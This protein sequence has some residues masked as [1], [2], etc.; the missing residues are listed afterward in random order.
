M[1]QPSLLCGHA[2]HADT[3]AA[4]NILAAGL[5]VSAFMKQ[6]PTEATAQELAHA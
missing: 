1:A 3:N 5:A 4:K 6:E 2:E